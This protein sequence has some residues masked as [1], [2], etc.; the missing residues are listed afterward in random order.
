MKAMVIHQHGT[1]DELVFDGNFPDPTPEADEVV[2]AVKATSLNYHDLF[3]LHGMPGIKIKMPMIMGIDV[4]GD[5]V[6]VGSEV[7]DWAVGDRV[8]IDPINRVKGGLVGETIEGGLA[9]YLK[10]PTHQL[11]KLPDDVSYE[12]AAALPVAYGTA[13]RMMVTRGDIKPGEK[14]LIL[15]ASGGVGTCCVQL[16]KMLGAEVVACAS[17]ADKLEKLKALGADHL[18]NYREQDWPQAV[19]NL[20]GKP[21]VFGQG[22]GGVDV[23]V[24]FTGGETWVPSLKVMRKDGRLLTCGATAGFD[25]KEDI[26]YIWTFELNIR[27]SN[28]WSREDLHALLDLVR[29]GK[30]KPSIDR[31][32]PLEGAKEALRLMEDRQIFGKLI[33][34][35]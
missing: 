35:P 5:I 33:I 30:I 11:I 18:I 9:E 3:T 34:R 16:A 1:L 29:T 32:M 21:R 10:V 4:A 25:P 12:D 7:K 13:H 23:V 31:V 15:G 20:Y 2:L 17:S 22:E 28:G 6:A 27:G 8:L 14:V 26:R 19:R 24:N